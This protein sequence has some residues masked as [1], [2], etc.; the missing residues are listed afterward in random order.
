[1]E[2]ALVYRVKGG[3]Q[4]VKTKA[5]EALK[6]EGFGILSEIPVS[7]VLKARVGAEGA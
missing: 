6:E 1:M 4:E 5:V 3:L 2:A 7:E